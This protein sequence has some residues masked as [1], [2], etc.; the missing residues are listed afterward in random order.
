MCKR[1]KPTIV[2]LLCILTSLFSPILYAGQAAGSAAGPAAYWDMDSMD[3][4]SIKDGSG[5]NDGTIFGNASISA[6]SKAGKGAISLNGV[7][8]YILVP[9]S[10]ALNLTEELSI[11][12]WIYSDTW[13]Y[14]NARIMQRGPGWYRLTGENGRMIFN[15]GGVARLEAPL[16]EINKWVH[17]AAAWDGLQMSLYYDGKLAASTAAS[18]VANS[19]IT[20]DWNKWE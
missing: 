3:A 1:H 16:P 12:A 10:A 17:I 15:I 9:G 11:T 18:G 14:K 20:R 5:G 4:D 8:G 13:E 7:T 19:V 2:L 6:D